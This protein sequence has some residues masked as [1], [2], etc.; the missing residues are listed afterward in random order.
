[1]S[2][3][4]GPES[5]N[6]VF[7]G[8]PPPLKSAWNDGKDVVVQKNSVRPFS[9]GLYVCSALKNASDTT[10]LCH[11]WHMW[12]NLTEMLVGFGLR[13]SSNVHIIAAD[14]QNHIQQRKG[15]FDGKIQKP[16]LKGRTWVKKDGESSSSTLWLKVRGF[17]ANNLIW[18]SI[19]N[20]VEIIVIAAV[21][22]G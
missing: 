18:I 13:R 1:M 2:F 6:S 21:I 11:L 16:K 8:G 22:T 10:F 4:A 9:L 7:P 14:S 5:A 20:F 3:E 19:I 17:V 12:T 15:A